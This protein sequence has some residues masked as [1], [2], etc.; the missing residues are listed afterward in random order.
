MQLLIQIY[1]AQ[2]IQLYYCHL[3]SLYFEPG[4]IAGD[5]SI[6]FF[7]NESYALKKYIE[8]KKVLLLLKH[9]RFIHSYN[10]KPLNFKTPLRRPSYP[11]REILV[12]FSHETKI[13]YFCTY[14]NFFLQPPVLRIA[15]RI[16]LAVRQYVSDAPAI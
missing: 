10:N 2:L 3:L 7:F 1:V 12:F 5:R 14:Y 6:N 4:K 15:Y 8:F 11:R 13:Q 16:S 9:H